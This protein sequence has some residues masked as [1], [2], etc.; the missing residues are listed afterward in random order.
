MKVNLDINQKNAVYIKEKNVLVVAS[1]GSGKTTVIINRVNHLIEDLKINEGNIIKEGYDE[2]VDRL[3]YVRQNG[4]SW[5]LDL[6]AKERELSK[7]E[8]LS[9]LP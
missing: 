3:R 8:Q 6:E 1:P 5:I 4:C 7:W 2:E 9:L